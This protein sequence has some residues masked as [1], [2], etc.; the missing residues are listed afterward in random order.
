M[1]LINTD[2]KFVTGIGPTKAKLFNE[3]LGIADI[4]DLL[5]YF[6]Y[7]YID[8]TKFYTIAELN[9]TMPYVQLKAQ[10]R[11]LETRGTGRKERL[12][13]TIA[14]E[15]GA[16]ELVWFKGLKYIKNQLKLGQWYIVFGKPTRFG[17]MLNIAHPEMEV[18]NQTNMEK[19][20]GW[21]AF[22]ITTEKMKARHLDSKAIGRLIT[23]IFQNY[24][25]NIDE[26]LPPE[27]TEKYHF[28]SRHRAISV[29]HQPP[30]PQLL[31]E[32]RQRLKYEELFFIQ[33]DI[34]RKSRNQRRHFRGI[35][36]STAGTLFNQFYAQH[37][38]F[39]LTGAQ[40][41]VIRTIFDDC[42]SGRQMNRL[43]QGDVG[44]GKTIVALCCSLI[45]IGNG[46]QA[47]IMAP[48][49]ILATQHY[50]SIS[51]LVEP[52]GINVKLLTGSTKQSQRT[53][54]DET[55]RNGTLNLLIGTHALLEDKVQ[56]KNLGFVTIDEQHRFGVA[57]RAR[58]WSK[59]TTPPHILV[60]T[61]TPIPRTLAMTIYGD[62]DVSIIDEL[63][64]G[65]KPIATYHLFDNKREELYRFMR[66]EITKGRQ[67]YIVYP[68]I[69]ESENL[70]IRNLMDGY[71]TITKQ[72]P[73]CKVSMVHGKLNTATKE[74]EMRKFAA[75]ETQ[76]MVAT[77]VIEVG[78]NV[79][80]ASVMV[81]ENAD[82][83][84]LSQ[85]HQLR[86]RVGRG[87][88]QSYCIL[89]SKHEISNDTRKRLSI[90]VDSNDGFV[91]AEADLKLRGP[92]DIDGTMQ[93]GLPFEL[94]IANLA[95]DGELLSQAR[96]D[97]EQLL[98]NDEQ[99]A[100]PEH[101][102]CL[103]RLQ[104]LNK[105]KQNWSDIS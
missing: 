58:L 77:T 96:H 10:L 92:G 42:R 94:R 38:P 70:D 67:I 35:T 24:E 98:D 104:Q 1:M 29:I 6:P 78:V 85:L 5:S 34:L 64:P 82:R 105:K 73:E 25:L 100:L 83:F 69:Q 53:I 43:L 21:Q 20:T 61:A 86:G 103:L 62:L 51:K 99:L 33:L 72:F 75:N 39:P 22:Y 50:E 63:P 101:Q 36:F 88:E 87:A 15:T 7:K 93:S 18:L 81:I 102:L 55:L 80:N 14:D 91:I 40:K 9:E 28:L 49:E 44:S 3:E 54:I 65:R 27:I 46:Y 32:A 57:Q 8:R 45:T 95:T 79:P 48:T 12:V 41:R 23:Q 47:C 90:M 59:N 97:V 71:D 60:M 89:M 26:T 2:I 31:Q 17:S 30:S 52:L 4:G 66:Q 13:A 37:L 76:I 19:L 68:L 74:E 84:G 11:T 56:F 16:M